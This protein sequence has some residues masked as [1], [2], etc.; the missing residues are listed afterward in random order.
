MS[1]NRI[2]GDSYGIRLSF[3]PLRQFRSKELISLRPCYMHSWRRISCQRDLYFRGTATSTVSGYRLF[4]D[5]LANFGVRFF[6][7]LAI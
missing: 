3:F 1:M 4:D 2:K 6:R 7:G 5:E